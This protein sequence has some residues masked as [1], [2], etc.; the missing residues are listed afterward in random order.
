MLWKGGDV[1]WKGGDVLWKGGDVLWKRGE[2][3]GKEAPRRPP[4][5]W[6]PTF[7]VAPRAAASRGPHEIRVS[8]PH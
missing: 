5:P 2:A 8:R 7:L 3:R 6:R 4:V 1:L